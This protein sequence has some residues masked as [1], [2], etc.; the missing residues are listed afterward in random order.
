MGFDR[1]TELLGE[2]VGERERLRRSK[3]V[4]RTM[5][6]RG[7]LKHTPLIGLLTRLV[8]RKPLVPPQARSPDIIIQGID[9]GMLFRL[10]YEITS[11]SVFNL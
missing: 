2:E 4:L 1:C 10:L 5:P 6:A 3:E 7:V 9:L 11:T 8:N